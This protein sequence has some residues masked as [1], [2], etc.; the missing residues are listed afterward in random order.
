MLG[1]HVGERVRVDG[2]EEEFVIL[3]VH[4]EREVADLLRM[5]GLRRIVEGV[6]LDS[7]RP[8]LKDGTER[9]TLLEN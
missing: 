7:L 6:A 4:P 9:R 3:L 2:H 8:L 1:L 5:T